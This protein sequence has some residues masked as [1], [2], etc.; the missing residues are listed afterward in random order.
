[1]SN[2]YT[3][4]ISSVNAGKE[5]K[6]KGLPTGYDRLDSYICGIQ[7]GRYDVVFGREGTGKSAF[8]DASYV[9]NPYEY[10]KKE[11][12]LNKL[13][14]LYY[15]LEISRQSKIAK[16]CCWK[17]YKDYKILTDTNYVLSKG[18]NRISNEIY[19]RVVLTADYF[20]EMSDVV[21]IYDEPLNP[22]GIWKQ[23]C[24]YAE[25]NGTISKDEKNR[26]VY[27]PNDPEKYTIII[28]D[29][30]GNLSLE[31]VADNYNAKSTIDK[32]SEYFRIFRNKFNFS[33]VLVSHANRSIEDINKVKYG[34]IF[35]TMSDIL[36]TNQLGQDANTVMCIFNP[37]TYMNPNNDMDKFMGY[38]IAKIRDRFRCV[39]VLKNREGEDNVRVGMAFIG[40]IGAYYELPKAKDITEKQYNAIG[41]MIKTIE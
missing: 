21:H 35:H 7:R 12:K 38:N 10:L 26:N 3:E 39:G 4:L 6:N 11:N 1:M 32:C 29:T 28:G 25:S 30:A 33:P 15:S 36:H 19:D 27:T 23:V 31:K 17:L 8:V 20:E 5:G 2:L 14:I 22:T 34:E 40:E 16:W 41:N 13:E 37:L 24:S 9:L 18:K